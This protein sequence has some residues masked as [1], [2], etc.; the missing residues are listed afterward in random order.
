MRAVADRTVGFWLRWAEGHGALTDGAGGKGG[1]GDA[2]MVVLPPPLQADLDL[3]EALSVTADPEVARED[4]ALLLIPG[5]PLLDRAAG[6]VLDDGDAGIAHL[7]WP[8]SLPPSAACLEAKAR[9]QLGV[10][11]GRIDVAGE[12]LP[13]YLPVLRLGVLVSFAVSLE[14]RFQER[15]EAWVDARTGLSVGDAA[16]ARFASTPWVPGP[17][18][19]RRLGPDLE[20]AVCAA[21]A[22]LDAR[23]RRRMEVVARH[24]A[25]AREAELARAE[26]YYA[27]TLD[28]VTRRKAAAA[29]E[30]QALYEEQ[31]RATEVERD[32]RVAEIHE[33]FRPRHEL[34]PF[35]AHILEVPALVLPVA[36]RRGERRYPFE[37]TWLPATR[38]FLAVSC[39]ACG[40]PGAPL[41]AGR[42]QLG[43]RAC[44]A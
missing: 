2:S 40:D 5:H 6:Q 44:L 15:Q 14:E 36:V 18:P 28:S 7:A 4:G 26:A 32:R 30:R 12:P 34:R 20:A 27:A 25:S 42:R 16:G 24:G 13:A 43:C 10:D 35:R 23:A 9:D 22:L 19:A 41:V 37:L 8:A 38:R 39:P 29:P 1:T 31:A 33:K 17:G 11:H 3:P 21:H